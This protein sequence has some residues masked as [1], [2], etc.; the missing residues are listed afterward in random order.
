MLQVLWMSEGMVCW[1]DLEKGWEGVAQDMEGGE[2]EA[3][4]Q[5]SSPLTLI[6]FLTKSNHLHSRHPDRSAMQILFNELYFK[7]GNIAV[8]IF[9]YAYV[10]LDMLQLLLL[11]THWLA[12]TSGFARPFS[13][14]TQWQVLFMDHC[15]SQ[16]PSEVV[17]LLPQT[18]V[19]VVHLIFTIYVFTTKQN[20]H[21]QKW[22][23]LLWNI[24]EW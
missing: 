17:G 10:L 20:V 16:T 24:S 5:V 2:T 1:Q 18:A 8:L 12:V 13:F 3:L 9:V 14:Q 6:V 15:M 23:I 4:L 7:A 22:I 11:A 19:D 21:S